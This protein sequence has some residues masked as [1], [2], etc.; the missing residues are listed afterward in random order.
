[1]AHEPLNAAHS[2]H[3]QRAARKQTVPNSPEYDRSRAALAELVQRDAKG[4]ELIEFV[5]SYDLGDGTRQMIS[6]W[7]H[8]IPDAIDR[9]DLMRQSLVYE[10]LSADHLPGGRAPS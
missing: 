4:N 9:V 3:V 10:G 8:N 7:A 6:F 2:F 1:V 5:A